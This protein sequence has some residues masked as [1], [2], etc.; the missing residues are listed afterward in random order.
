MFFSRMLFTSSLL[1]MSPG[2]FF[3]LDLSLLLLLIVDVVTRILPGIVVD[4]Q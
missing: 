3:F 1:M 4:A 2:K